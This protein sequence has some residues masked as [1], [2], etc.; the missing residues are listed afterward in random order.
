MHTLVLDVQIS[1]GNPVSLVDSPEY[2]AVSNQSQ[3]P[4]VGFGP[5]GIEIHRSRVPNLQECMNTLLYAANIIS[6]TAHLYNILPRNGKK[7]S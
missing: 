5:E 6:L 7:F 4:V 2:S 1:R 3:S